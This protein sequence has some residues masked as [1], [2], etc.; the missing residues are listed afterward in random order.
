MQHREVEVVE[1]AAHEVLDQVAH[2]GLADTGAAALRVHRQAPEAGAAFWVVEGFVVVEAHDGANHLGIP[3][4]LGQP[5]HRAAQMARGDGLLVH[6]QHAAATVELVD[7][8]PVGLAQRA[9][10]ADTAKRLVGGAVI[11]K[12]EPQGIGGVK[13]QLLWRLG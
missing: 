3:S 7:R 6:R 13:E 10:N 5:V 1:P 4:V 12:P 8:E 11:G 2:Q 9:A